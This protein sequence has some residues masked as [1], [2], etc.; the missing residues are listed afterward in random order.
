VNDVR[1]NEAC[2]KLLGGR[3]ESVAE[4]AYHSGFNSITNFNRVFKTSVGKSPREYAAEFF[5]KVN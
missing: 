5:R 2:K 3:Y 1:I 4:V